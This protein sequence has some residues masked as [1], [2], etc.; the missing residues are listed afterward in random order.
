MKGFRLFLDSATY[1]IHMKR[2]YARVAVLV[3]LS[4]MDLRTYEIPLLH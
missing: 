2:A 3:I 1:M 4:D